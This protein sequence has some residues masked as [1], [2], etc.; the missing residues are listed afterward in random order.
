LVVSVVA[1][2]L[3]TSWMHFLVAVEIVVHAHVCAKGKML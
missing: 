2:D 1:A 3:A